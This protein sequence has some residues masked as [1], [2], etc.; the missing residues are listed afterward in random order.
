MDG[1]V[2]ILQQNNHS[3][4]TLQWLSGK[5][6]GCQG[7]GLLISLGAKSV[8]ASIAPSCLVKP[9]VGDKVVIACA[10][11]CYYIT[12]V[13]EKITGTTQIAIQGDLSI[14]SSTGKIELTAPKGIA[15]ATNDA[16]ILSAKTCDQISENHQLLTHKLN[17]AGKEIV[18]T[19]DQA[20]LSASIASMVVD[21]FYQR[22]RQIV[23]WVET[24]ES[25]TIGTLIQQVKSHM[26]IRSKNMV[27]TA[28]DDVKIDGERIHMG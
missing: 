5:V 1:K 14:Q 22:A 25:S 18:V 11:S 27:L 15:L 23:K 4:E 7:Q 9:D 21:D 19:S 10:D 26:N 8:F 20:Q 12:T 28:E 2:R 3:D 6:E 24:M 16:L 13:L 17:V